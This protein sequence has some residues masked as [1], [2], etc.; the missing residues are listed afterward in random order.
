MIPLILGAVALGTGVFGVGTGIVGVADINDAKK[1][2][3]HAQERYERAVSQL[4]VDREAANK[5]AEN[6]GQLQL[7]IIIST[8]KRFVVFLEQIGQ[9]TSQDDWQFLEGLEISIQQLKEYKATVIQAEEWLKGSASAAFAGAAAASGAASFAKSFGTATVTNTVTRF[10][11]LWTT[12]VVTEVGISQLSGAAARSA[13]VAWLGGGSTVVGGF[14]LG[15]ITLGPALMT[16][17]LQLAGKGQEALTKARDY[18]CKVNTAVAEI[19]KARDKLQ[20]AQQRIKELRILVLSLNHQAV[21]GLHELESQPFFDKDRDVSKFQQVALLVKALVE[22][23]RTPILD[24][25]GQL[26]PD[27]VTIRAKYCNLGVK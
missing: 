19:E 22:I 24:D 25:E 12:E 23:I 3:E 20:F 16:G 14:V 13:I 10:F 8:I 2:G 21:F 18:N 7:D 17:G 26:N 1:I 15:G 9:R 5:V 4:K 6:Y 11:G 27:T